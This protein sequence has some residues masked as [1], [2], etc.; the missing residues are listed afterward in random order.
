M[1]NLTNF[2]AWWQNTVHGNYIKDSELERIA[3]SFETNK[4]QVKKQVNTSQI[5]NGI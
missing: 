1:E 5:N 3:E 4:K 2:Y